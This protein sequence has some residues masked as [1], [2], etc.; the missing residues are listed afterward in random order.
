MKCSEQFFNAR[1]RSKDCNQ[2]FINRQPLTRKKPI[3]VMQITNF[4]H[5][6][7]INKEFAGSKLRAEIW[8]QGL[9]TGSPTLFIF[10]VGK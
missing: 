7:K 10:Q 2:N 4:Y 8:E 5:M 6:Y 1:F 9:A 3:R